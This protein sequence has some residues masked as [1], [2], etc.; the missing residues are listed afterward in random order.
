[1][2]PTLKRASIIGFTA[3]TLS[4]S[5]ALARVEQNACVPDINASL[6]RLKIAR[7]A[8]LA[9][10]TNGKVPGRYYTQSVF[11]NFGWENHFQGIQRLR[12]SEYLVVSGGILS[13]KLG[14]LFVVK[15]ESRAGKTDYGSNLGGGLF[16]KIPSRDRIISRI[17]VGDKTRWHPG[18]MTQL[19][20][21]L[22]VPVEDN[23]KTHSSL[24]LFFDFSDPENPKKLSV[25]I[26]RPHDEA[27][28]VGMERLRDGRFLVSA[29]SG[30]VI[31]FYYS[32]STRIE[33]GFEERKTRWEPPQGI[34]VTGQSGHLVRQCDGR[35]FFLSA[36]NDGKFAPVLNGKD[37]L[38]LFEIRGVHGTP[39]DAPVV[40][41]L[42]RTHFECKGYCNFNAATGIYVGDDRR[43]RIYSAPH[44]RNLAG[45]VFKLAE[46]SENQ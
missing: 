2:T 20:D 3:F 25:V 43:V 22:V 35:L 14:H 12:N 5:A 10:K 37:W 31:D 44:F 41:D 38:S 29:H 28:N 11:A 4:S 39:S 24:I 32:K 45:T 9:S 17:D 30:G 13:K 36:R 18:G 40:T 8:N 26:D 16:K 7:R 1:M 33:D 19:G 27:G 6:S 23:N 42:G 34:D 15:L 21:I 46:F